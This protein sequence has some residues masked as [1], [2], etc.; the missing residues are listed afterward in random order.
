M[1]KLLRQNGIQIIDHLLAFG[2]NEPQRKYCY[3]TVPEKLYQIFTVQ[4]AILKTCPTMPKVDLKN[5]S[6]QIQSTFD[7]YKFR[8]MK[9][10]EDES[11]KNF[12]D[13]AFGS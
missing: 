5:I 13:A 3:Y 2:I 9:Q 12:K 4:L 6:S 1:L 7:V 11:S 8:Q 10:L